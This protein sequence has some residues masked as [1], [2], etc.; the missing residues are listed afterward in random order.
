MRL[1]RCVT[2]A[3]AASVCFSRSPKL[4]LGLLSITTT[5]TEGSAS[6]SSR[7][8]DGLASASAPKASATARIHAPRLLIT[9]SS[10]PTIAATAI[11]AHRISLG[12]S[13]ANVIPKPTRYAFSARERGVRC[14]ALSP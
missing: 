13:G 12:T 9:S 1:S 10:V 8:S 11:A 7:V 3:R 2:A 4:W 14:C 5:A 6:R